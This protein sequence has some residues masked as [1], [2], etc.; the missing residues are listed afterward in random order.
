MNHQMQVF[1][2]GPRE[3]MSRVSTEAAAVLLE[4]D[5]LLFTWVGASAPAMESVRALKGHLR[6][7]D[8]QCS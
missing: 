8:L 4:A 6:P 2:L 5:L 1:T 3:M 7:L